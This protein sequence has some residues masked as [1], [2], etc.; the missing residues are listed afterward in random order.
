MTFAKGPVQKRR[1][2]VNAT[3]LTEVSAGRPELQAESK[4]TLWAD[5]S[6]SG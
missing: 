6:W 5:S 2:D 1:P 4:I 3:N